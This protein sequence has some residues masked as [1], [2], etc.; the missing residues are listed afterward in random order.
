[1]QHEMNRQ[2]GYWVKQIARKRRGMVR[3]RGERVKEEMK[4]LRHAIGQDD[5][6]YQTS[7]MH[8]PKKITFIFFFLRKEKK[9]INIRKVKERIREINEKYDDEKEK[10]GWEKKDISIYEKGE[11][12]GTLAWKVVGMRGR[13][14]AK[15]TTKVQNKRKQ[16]AP[17]P[18]I[19]ST[20][21]LLL[22]CFA[23]SFCV[24][25]HL[26]SSFFAWNHD[27]NSKCHPYFACRSFSLTPRTK[28]L[29]KQK[30]KWQKF[31]KPQKMEKKE[32]KKRTNRKKES[33]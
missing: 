32:I 14:C 26:P 1:M 5:G 8:A 16:T 11:E 28:I 19:P 12:I 3:M 17:I 13:T 21:C 4:Y 24:P 7:K 27:K 22:S 31:G 10:E 15:Q 25:F 2:G 20:F 29:D 6:S 30:G 33:K 23:P 9:R 18:L